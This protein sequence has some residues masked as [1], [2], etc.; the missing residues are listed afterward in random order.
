[1]AGDP[2]A[3]GLGDRGIPPRDPM[4]PMNHRVQSPIP[5]GEGLWTGRVEGSARGTGAS[6]SLCLPASQSPRMSAYDHLFPASSITRLRVMHHSLFAIRL[7][8][9]LDVAPSD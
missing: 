3:T 9:Q 7:A 6:P 5:W 2:H 1:M 4:Y 8:E